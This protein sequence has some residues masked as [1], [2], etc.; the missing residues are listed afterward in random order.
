M[1]YPSTHACAH[2]EH[3]ALSSCHNSTPSA[4]FRSASP[5]AFCFVCRAAFCVAR[6]A[7]FRF[8]CPHYLF[9][10]LF[11]PKLSSILSCY[12]LLQIQCLVEEEPMSSSRSSSSLV[13]EE[14]ACRR[15]FAERSPDECK[16][17]SE[18]VE[19]GSGKDDQG[20]AGAAGGHYPR[21]R[22]YH[23][24]DQGDASQRAELSA[25]ASSSAT[26]SPPPSYERR[27]GH[28]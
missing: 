20:V 8:A 9:W 15:S 12:V 24:H 6:P 23:E 18:D 17:V 2:R 10:K 19:D 7:A 28:A 21:K 3:V 25:H 11:R 14:T 4:I 1:P 26:P 5:T 27:A 22:S 13:E 16:C